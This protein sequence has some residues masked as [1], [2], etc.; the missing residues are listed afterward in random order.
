[1]GGHGDQNQWAVFVAFGI[2]TAVTVILGTLKWYKAEI[3]PQT[4]S[5]LDDMIMGVLIAATPVV[6]FLLGAIS[7]V[8]ILGYNDN[9]TMTVINDWVG[10]HL[11]NLG[12]SR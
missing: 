6:G 10:E 4:N 5:S 9:P 8:N 2:Y 11:A 3:C 1:V 7:I 12:S